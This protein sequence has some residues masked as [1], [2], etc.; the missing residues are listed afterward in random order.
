MSTVLTSTQA[1]QQEKNMKISTVLH[2]SVLTKLA[3]CAVFFTSLLTIALTATSTARNMSPTPAIMVDDTVHTVIISAKRLSNEQKQA[4]A[5]QEA[6]QQVQT[7]V[8][9]AKR[10]SASE[11]LA[12]LRQEQASLISLNSAARAKVATQFS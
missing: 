4:M 5:T 6:A 7:V 10:L 12:S 2:P 3:L 8:L 11:K 1:Y 9:T